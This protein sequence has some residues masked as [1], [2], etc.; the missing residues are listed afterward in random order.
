LIGG[1]PPIWRAK[2]KNALRFET[3][4]SRLWV[5]SFSGSQC[6]QVGF[7]FFALP[8][9]PCGLRRAGRFPLFLRWFGSGTRRQRGYLSL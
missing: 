7:R 2:G 9:S 3:H 8:P 5:G 6:S 4:R 1:H